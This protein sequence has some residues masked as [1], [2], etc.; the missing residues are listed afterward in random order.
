M[1]EKIEEIIE[2]ISNLIEKENYRNELKDFRFIAENIKDI[3][4]LQNLDLDILYVSPSI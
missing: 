3:I 2:S 4:F 1:G